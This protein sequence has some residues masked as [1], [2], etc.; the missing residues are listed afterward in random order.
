MELAAA[1]LLAAG[2]VYALTRARRRQRWRRPPGRRVAVPPPGAARAEA[3]LLLGEDISAA[4]LLDTGLRHLGAV[5]TRQGRTPPTVFAAHVGEDN[6]DLWV[7]PAS[8]DAPAPWYAVGDGQV[9]RLPLAAAAGLDPAVAG[10]EVAPYPGLVSIG[11]D[12]TGRVLVDVASAHGLI[13]VTGPADLVQDSIV[14]VATELATAR[15]AEQ[16]HLT[17][18]GFGED[19]AVLDPARVEVVPS[20]AAA[21]PR[22][23]AWAAEITDAAALRPPSAAGAEGMRAAAWEPRYLISALPPSPGWEEE[24]LLALARA[25]QAAGAGYITA[26]HVRGAAWTWEITNAGRLRAAELG[27]EVEAQRIPREARAGLADLFATAGDLAGAPLS[28]PT[29][30]TAAPVHTEPGAGAPVEVTLLGPASVSAPGEIEQE[31]L[32]I[33]TE[34]VVYLATHP[35]GV[36]PNVLSAAL[37]PRGVTP[38]VRDALLDRVGAW[39]GTDELGRPHLARDTTGRLRLGSEVRVDWHMFCSLAALAAQAAEAAASGEGTGAHTRGGHGHGVH[40]A[41]PA[42]PR[43]QLEA[44]LLGQALSLVSGPFLDCRERGRY[45]WLAVDGLEFEVEARVA[46][47]AHRLCELRLDAGDADGAVEAV[48]AGLRLASFDEQL[49]RDLLIAAHATGQEHQVRAVVR[50]ICDWASLYDLP[51][52]APETEALID[53]IMPSWR[54]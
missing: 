45:A 3:A 37:W 10:R 23:E 1:G 27:L 22:L 25:G 31:R 9:W 5:L 11:T 43:A 7:A 39:L 47:A 53:E 38:E 4:G 49:W 16:I 54:G 51:G 33:A 21:L 8:M 40:A 44:T 24:R 6:I 14:A 17:L 46:D 42:D 26:G 13:A 15:W 35:G 28:A 48:R 50:E 41:R 19:L 20:L 18:A 32:Q 34:L 2:A 30:D 52:M 36:H 12:S 29:L